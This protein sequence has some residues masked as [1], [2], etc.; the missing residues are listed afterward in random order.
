MFLEAVQQNNINPHTIMKKKLAKWFLLVAKRL[1]QETHVENA[2]HIEDY[3]AQ[4]LGL[5]YVITKKDIKDF[6]FKDGARMSVRQGE[7]GIIH[8][9]KKNIRKYIIAGI[10]ANRLIEY[11]VK[12]EDGGF[13]I[14]GELKVYVRK[15]E[16]NGE[17]K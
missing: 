5:T 1:D 12:R 3:D 11:D 7:R 6:R 10:D 13:R 8:E 2:Q 9:V 15:S 14:G 17:V 4:K 16:N